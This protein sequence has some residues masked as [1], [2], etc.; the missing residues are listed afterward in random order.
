[1]K[2]LWEKQNG[3]CPYTGWKLELP[4]TTTGFLD[5]QS[6]KRASVDRIN[7]SKGYVEGNIQFVSVIANFAKNTFSDDQLIEF[8]KAVADYKK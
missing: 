3:I 8:C 6:S 4:R 5:N 2:S 7:I 1:M